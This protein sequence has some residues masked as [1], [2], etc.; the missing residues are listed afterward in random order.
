[1]VVRSDDVILGDADAEVS[2]V[3]ELVQHGGFAPKTRIARPSNCYLLGG[4][5]LLFV[6]AVA[7]VAKLYLIPDQDD[8]LPALHDVVDEGTLGNDQTNA[9]G[10]SIK[11]AREYARNHKINDADLATWFKNHGHHY[12]PDQNMTDGED[13][14]I[15]KNPGFD[16]EKWTNS[17]VTLADGPMFEIVRQLVHD[18]SAFLEGLTYEGGFLYE[19]TGLNGKSTIRKLDAYTGEIIESYP[20][21]SK[22]F[23]EGLAIAHGKAYQ[24]TYQKKTGFIYNLTDLSKPL[25]T[26]QFT[27]TT[28]EGWGFTYNQNQDEFVMSDGSDFLHFWDGQTLTEKRKVKVTR[29][30]GKKSDQI[31]ELEFYHGRVLANIWYEDTICVI[32]PATGI[33]EKEYGKPFIEVWVSSGGRGKF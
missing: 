10:G 29:Q 5:S 30:N 27:S 13:V 21:D 2:D 14:V 1:M 16:R 8:V 18:P 24:L 4:F 17:T 26:F 28:N 6:A 31:N 25:E 12:Q 23:G 19:S 3:D 7:V 22:Y 32:N 11:D 33:V 20:L 9:G 15:S